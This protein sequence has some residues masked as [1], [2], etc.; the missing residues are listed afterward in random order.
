M[1]VACLQV[2]SHNIVSRLTTTLARKCYNGTVPYDLENLSFNRLQDLY[3]QSSNLK[4]MVFLKF[5]NTL[6]LH[7]F[8]RKAK[9]SVK[10]MRP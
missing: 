9:I 7:Y 2:N 6:K 5:K 1:N 8:Y 3:L 4:A 10:N